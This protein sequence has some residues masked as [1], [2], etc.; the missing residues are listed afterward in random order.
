MKKILLTCLIATA[1]FVVAQT[2]PAQTPILTFSGTGTSLTVG[3]G[4][5]ALR[6][7]GFSTNSST[8]VSLDTA[9]AL[10]LNLSF[11]STESSSGFTVALYT[12]TVNITPSSPT[13]SAPLPNNSQAPV[14]TFVNP[15]FSFNNTA[16]TYQFSLS[17]PV[18]LSASTMYWLVLS[19]PGDTTPV[20]WVGQSNSAGATSSDGLSQIKVDS[21]SGI[22]G[23]LFL[24]GST[25][26]LSGLDN[27]SG[28]T[29]DFTLFSA[30]AVPEPST[31]ALLFFGMVGFALFFYRKKLAD[32]ALS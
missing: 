25:I 24:S 21:G 19:A 10:S 14:A 30:A 8:S 5:Q 1:A 2:A 29:G 28:S 17:S 6:G 4:T 11:S 7:L 22:T 27:V 20:T 31:W 9:D 16:T 23:S 26:S 3:A 32:L 12:S 15:T 13:V 18:T